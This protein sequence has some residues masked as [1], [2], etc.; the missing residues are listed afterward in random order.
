M[1]FNATGISRLELG[2]VFRLQPPWGMIGIGTAVVVA[3]ALLSSLWPATTAARSE[4][5]KL[6]QSGRAAI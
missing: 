1:S 4:P 2:Y 5:L 6:L 3:V